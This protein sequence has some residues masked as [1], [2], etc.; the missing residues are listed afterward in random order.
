MRFRRK[1]RLSLLHQQN[2]TLLENPQNENHFSSNSNLSK[3]NL[4]QPKGF[5]PRG[6]PFLS[7]FPISA[8]T[9][10]RSFQR[11]YYS[12]ALCRLISPNR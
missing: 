5:T 10:T 1:T 6:T 3:Y 12:S 11:R 7:T 4:P 9:P 2:L 8:N